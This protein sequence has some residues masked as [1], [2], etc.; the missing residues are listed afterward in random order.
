MELKDQEVLK[1]YTEEKEGTEK[2]VISWPSIVVDI[3]SSRPKVMTDWLTDLKAKSH[4]VN[5]GFFKLPAFLFYFS[6]WWWPSHFT[7]RTVLPFIHQ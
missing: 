1:S 5:T 3:F 4:P 6:C 7:L 2:K